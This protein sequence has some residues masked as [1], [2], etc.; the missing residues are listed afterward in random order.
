MRMDNFTRA[1]GEEQS[2]D[3]RVELIAT[4]LPELLVLCDMIGA[5]AVKMRTVLPQ[6]K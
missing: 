1:D 4:L 5:Y 6:K 3:E 2:I